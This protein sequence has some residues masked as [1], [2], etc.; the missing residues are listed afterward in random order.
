M[1]LRTGAVALALAAGFAGG[2]QAADQ[3][4]TATSANTFV[5]SDVTVNAGDTVTWTNSGGNHNVKFDD[6]SFE[7]PADVQPPGGA[8]WPV[9][10]TFGSVG[11][12]SYYCELHGGAGGVGMAGIVRVVAAPAGPDQPGPPPQQPGSPGAPPPDPPGP[13]PGPK[14]AP[15]KVSF[16]VS[17]ATPVRGSRVRLSGFVRPARDGR[18]V[19]IQQR[20]RGGSFRTIATA[21]LLDAGSAKSRFSVRLKAR[22]DAVL[23]VRVAGDSERGAGVSATRKLDV[24]RPRR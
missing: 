20:G 24:T 2:A 19:Q 15:L 3:T 16:S 14:P 23:R 21:R 10:R 18:R 17:D 1:V 8:G 4:V 5:S 12:F 22:A 9:T 13:A 6:G 11:M 7:S